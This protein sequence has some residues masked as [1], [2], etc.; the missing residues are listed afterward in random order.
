MKG[1]LFALGGILLLL[2]PT[3]LAVIWHEDSDY[4]TGVYTTSYAYV[5]I[6]YWP[7]QGFGSW[8][9]SGGTTINTTPPMGGKKFYQTYHSDNW[10]WTHAWYKLKPDGSGATDSSAFAQI[11]I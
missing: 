10:G 3:A 11:D 4:D 8:V 2:V 6:P 7:G 9:H 5:G 1:K